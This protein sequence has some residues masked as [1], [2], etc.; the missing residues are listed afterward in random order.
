MPRL[1]RWLRRTALY[2]SVAV[3]C[4]LTSF[5]FLWMVITVFKQDRDLY[6]SA[7]IPFL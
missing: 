1:N 2:L 4:F 3:F 7:G 6:R 5:P